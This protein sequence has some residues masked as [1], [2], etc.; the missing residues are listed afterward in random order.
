[1]EDKLNDI[2]IILDSILK[3]LNKLNKTKHLTIYN[4]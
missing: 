1:M 4:W 2:L 3:K